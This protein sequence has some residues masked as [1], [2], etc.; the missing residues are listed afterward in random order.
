MD[1]AGST[2]TIESFVT[3]QMSRVGNALRRAITVPYAD[4]F[5]VT[6]AEWRMLSVLA[7]A[8]EL[9]FPKLVALSATDKS[10]VSR[11]L[12]L[13]EARDLVE[14]EAEPGAPRKGLMCRIT[15]AGL[16]MYK[17]VMPLARQ[18]QAAMLRV[19][20]REE[21]QV[22]YRALRKLHSHC[23]QGDDGTLEG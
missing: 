9:P 17:Q 19:L 20:T 4:Q 3:T 12:R 14:I 2:L 23:L 8:R 21:R 7:E 16:T 11:A 1:E 6:V 10:L 5:G 18:R 22:M 15:P 13:L